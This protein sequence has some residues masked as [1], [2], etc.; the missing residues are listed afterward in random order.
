MRRDTVWNDVLQDLINHGG[1]IQPINQQKTPYYDPFFRA[2]QKGHE[3]TIEL[4][5]KKG[6]NIN[7][8]FHTWDWGYGTL[9]DQAI[10]MKKDN[11]SEFGQNLDRTIALLRKYGTFTLDEL[12]S[13]S[14]NK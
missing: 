9:L 10:G 3:T 11:A 8:I 12:E 4:L 13:K 5:L 2:A 7:K 14:K 6:G 1:I